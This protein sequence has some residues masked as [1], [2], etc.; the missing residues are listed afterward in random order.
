MKGWD[1]V[2]VVIGVGS[3]RDGVPNLRGQRS[4]D[5]QFWVGQTGGEKK[6]PR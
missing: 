3:M 5:Y 6:L 2:I 1:G 4:R